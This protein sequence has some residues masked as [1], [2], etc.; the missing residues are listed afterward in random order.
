VFKVKKCYFEKI[1]VIMITL[2][3]CVLLFEIGLRISGNKSS[4]VSQG[5]YAQHEN[6]YRLEKNYNKVYNWS[7]GIFTVCTN[8][9]G[10]RDKQ[11]GKINVDENP[12]IVFLGASQVFGMGVDYEDSFVGILA[13]YVSN[14]GI[15]IR[16]LAVG[17]HYFIEQEEL[18]KDFIAKVSRKPSLI[19]FSVNPASLRGFDHKHTN[20]L[21]KSGYLFNRESWKIAYLKLTLQNNLSI[22]VFLRDVLWKLDSV[23]PILNIENK[24]LPN[25]L[26]LYLKDSRLNDQEEMKK[27]KDHLNRFENYCDQIGVKLIYLYVP[28]IDSFRMEKLLERFGEDSRNYDSSMYERIIKDYC[29]EHQRILLNPKPILKKHFDQGEKLRFDIDAHYNHFGNCVVGDYLIEK[30]FI[31]HELF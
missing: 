6:T 29:K 23:W 8:S 26:K 4:N 2:F 28:L 20:I 18:L 21:V 10:M 22:Y 12:Y 17:G 14:K 1:T 13:D 15:E 3:F 9:F 24:W 31:E 11:T 16:N 27:L 7:S 25:H 30:V 5:E 19:I